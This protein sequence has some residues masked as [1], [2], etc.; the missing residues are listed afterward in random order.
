MLKRPPRNDGGPIAQPRSLD[1]I[2]GTYTGGPFGIRQNTE[3]HSVR[4]YQ[5][6]VSLLEYVPLIECFCCLCILPCTLFYRG[7]LTYDPDQRLAP[8]QAQE[9]NFIK[10]APASAEV[11]L[12]TR[13]LDPSGANDFDIE[14]GDSLAKPNGVYSI[15]IEDFVYTSPFQQS[16]VGG[17]EL[18]QSSAGSARDAKKGWRR[19]NRKRVDVSRYVS[20]CRT[21]HVYLSLTA[22][23]VKP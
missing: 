18:E 6:F 10:P 15:A 8:K 20:F 23:V 13:E 16:K 2:I 19:S 11:E 3:G 9:H 22:V 5:S 14:I 1:A 21:V 12:E 4:R 7:M 17:D